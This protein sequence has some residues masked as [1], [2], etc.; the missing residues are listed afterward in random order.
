M[1]FPLQARVAP[2]LHRADHPAVTCAARY[3]SPE[4]PTPGK[5]SPRGGR[6][7]G[8]FDAEVLVGTA[9]QP[10]HRHS[11]IGALSDCGMSYRRAFI[12]QPSSRIRS[13]DRIAHFMGEE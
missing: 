5:R 4:L 6:P 13:T 7:S 10:D 9:A 11:P 8:K 12:F 1:G 2:C 3:S